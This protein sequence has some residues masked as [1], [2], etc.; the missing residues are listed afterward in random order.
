LPEFTVGKEGTA[1]VADE[2]PAVPQAEPVVLKIAPVEATLMIEWSATVPTYALLLYPV[3]WNEVTNTVSIG[4]LPVASGLTDVLVVKPFAFADGVP[5]EP[6]TVSD[7]VAGSRV[8]RTMTLNHWL[9]VSASV[10]CLKQ[11]MPTN[12]LAVAAP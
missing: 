1:S 5:K 9:E 11:V 10:Y 4:S 6:L 12:G 7:P 8:A 3:Y 2:P